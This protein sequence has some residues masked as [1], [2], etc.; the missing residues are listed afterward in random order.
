[1]LT[2]GSSIKLH[3]VGRLDGGRVFYDTHVSG[4]VPL[5]ITI[6]NHQLLPALEEELCAM[7]VGERRM[8]SI[9]AE[10]AY[11][12]YDPTL[13]EVVPLSKFPN[14]DQLTVGEY[15]ILNSDQGP[16]RLKVASIENGEVTFDYNHEL[17]GHDLEF[18][19]DLL[20][21]LPPDAGAVDHERYY[22]E[23]DHCCHDL[24]GEEDACHCAH[25]D[26]TADL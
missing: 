5:E 19:V 11:G 26:T 15:I 21:V 20:K 17:A 4:G 10:R 14:S 12:T 8:I 9:P 3:M 1:M 2:A 13:I 24:L 25:G 22:A 6:G 16:I 18:Q 7:E 23:E